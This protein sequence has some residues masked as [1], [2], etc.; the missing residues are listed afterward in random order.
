M[1]YMMTPNRIN[2]YMV[3]P[4]QLGEYDSYMMTPDRLGAFTAGQ[5]MILQGGLCVAG[6]MFAGYMYGPKNG[7]MPFTLIGAVI[8][9][10]LYSLLQ[11]NSI[12][13]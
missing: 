6:G 11:M 10:T 12:G 4:D 8:G 13:G 9:G 2:E 7:K 3:S 5:S 1:P